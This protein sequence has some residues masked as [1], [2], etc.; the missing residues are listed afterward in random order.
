[1]PHRELAV[2]LLGV[3]E[4]VLDLLLAVDLLY[5]ELDLEDVGRAWLEL[6]EVV[7]GGD[8]LPA[9]VDVRLAENVRLYDGAQDERHRRYRKYRPG[10]GAEQA[11]AQEVAAGDRVFLQLRQCC[12]LLTYCPNPVGGWLGSTVY[13]GSL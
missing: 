1:M 11:K 4:L 6:L 13:P 2:G 3:R 12:P 5:R 8:A 7:D 9:L 10:D